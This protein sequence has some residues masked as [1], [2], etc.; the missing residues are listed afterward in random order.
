[1]SQL[2]ISVLLLSGKVCV[3]SDN[4]QNTLNRLCVQSAELIILGKVATTVLV[5]VKVNQ[6]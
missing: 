3:C 5:R 1:V 2:R 6:Y 4:T